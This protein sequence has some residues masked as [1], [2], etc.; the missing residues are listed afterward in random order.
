[1]SISPFTAHSTILDLSSAFPQ[2]DAAYSVGYYRPK[3]FGPEPISHHLLDFKNG[4]RPQVDRWVD[5]ASELTHEFIS[6][7]VVVRVLGRNE[8]MAGGDKPLDELCRA[9]AYKEGT[10]VYRPDILRKCRTTRSL[11]ELGGAA[12]RERE[13]SG[14]FRVDPRISVRSGST[15]LVVDDVVTT[16]STAYA[17]AEVL[18]DAFRGAKV[19]LFALTRTDRHSPNSHLNPAYF[20]SH[21]R[22]PTQRPR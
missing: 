20:V 2:L 18:R 3:K 1:M 22:W 15:I 9:I 21:P 12:N 19:V 7:D 16:G 10:A 4:R 13:V 14:V 6:F 5:L 17:I 11:I 8:L